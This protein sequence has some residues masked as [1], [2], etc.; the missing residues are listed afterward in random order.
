MKLPRALWFLSLLTLLVAAAFAVD[1]TPW[2]RGGF[3]WRWQYAP[4][5][6]ARVLPLLLAVSVY[7]AVGAWLLL[8]RPRLVLAWALIGAVVMS[9]TAAHARS[10][11]ALGLL[12][13]RTASL[14][15]SGEHPAAAMIDWGGGEWRDWTA[16]MARYS[17]NLGTSPP[18]MFMLYAL[19]AGLF[20]STPAAADALYRTLLPYQCHNYDLLALSPVWWAAAWFGILTPLFAALGVLPLWSIVRRAAG[21]QAAQIAVLWYALI[22][23]MA[24]FATSSS[25]LFPLLALLIFD[26]L[27]R[28]LDHGGLTRRGALWLL[29]A[30]VLYGLGL[31]LNFVFLPLAALYGLYALAHHAL[32]A[33]RNGRP[34]AALLAAG[35]WVL[36]GAALPW[37][38]FTLATGQTFF[39]LL[40]QSLSYHLQLDRPYAFWVWFHVWDWAV[41]TGLLWVLLAVWGLWRNLRGDARR[42]SPP[43]IGVALAL[44]VLALTLSG[45]TR[46]ESGRVWLFLAPFAAAAGAE[47]LVRWLPRDGAA[48][49]RAWAL[50]TGAQAALMIALLL[51]VDAYPAP[52]MTPP[53]VPVALSAAQP[54]DA[55]FSDQSDGSQF[56]LTGWDFDR[57]SHPPALVL[58]WE[59]GTRA[60]GPHWFGALLIAPD[61]ATVPVE[62]WQ[63][64]QA[65]GMD[66]RFPTTCWAPGLTV[67]DR[68][69]LPLTADAAAGDWWIS[70]AA[71]GDDSQPEGRLTVTTGTGEADVQVG[72][73]PL[74]MP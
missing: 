27:A 15:A 34:F 62:A 28:G 12:F 57:D 41:W 35:G 49:R 26:L 18:G 45:T 6:D 56:R 50:I 31:F 72:L 61:G 48:V 5:L 55:L 59:G 44:A 32:V 33:R 52:D 9:V 46:G 20:E 66:A 37:A 22:P 51:A 74:V 23:G 1:L 21:V 24:A 36:M 16:A 54:V 38:L 3:G 60:T 25:T 13:E 4:V 30:G 58:R 17:G 64:K 43:L 47:S 69:P 19:T 39:D 65:E 63:P 10:G 40:G 68:V 67:W 53:A 8:R 70:L 73:G 7:V 71:F 14:V 11:D 2:L 29:A 42:T